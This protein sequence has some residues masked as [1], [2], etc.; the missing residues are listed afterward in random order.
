MCISKG[1]GLKEAL[2]AAG[3]SATAYYHLTHQDNILPNTLQRLAN[4]LEVREMD[5]L[6]QDSREVW[7]T[8]K[9]MRDVN[10]IYS[11]NPKMDPDNIHPAGKNRKHPGAHLE[12]GAH[13]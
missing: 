12:V 7:L 13:H 2:K 3:I 10:R 8:K 5:L 9:I 4:F 1:L 11:Q 6:E